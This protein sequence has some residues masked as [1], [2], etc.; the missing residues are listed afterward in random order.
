MNDKT[1]EAENRR[2]RE[3]VAELMVENKNLK[4]EN[5]GLNDKCLEA[6]DVVVYLFEKKGEFFNDYSQQK[7]RV[8][9][10]P[11]LSEE[12][13]NFLTSNYGKRES[14]P[15]L[16]IL[17][18]EFRNHMDKLCKSGHW[19]FLDVEDEKS[20]TG[21]VIYKHGSDDPIEYKSIY[22]TMSK[23]SVKF[24]KSRQLQKK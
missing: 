17:L 18:N 15:A 12:I 3:R 8:R 13:E 6:L 16:G 4:E 5:Q 23:R 9:K 24:R 7:D 21:F 14:I 22:N 1:L 19:F 20:G 2:L 10:L 11:P